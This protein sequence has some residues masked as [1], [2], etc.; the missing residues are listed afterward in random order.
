MS[1][2]GISGRKPYG[3]RTR[4]IETRGW[5]RLEANRMFEFQQVSPKDFNAILRRSFVWRAAARFEDPRAVAGGYDDMWR[6]GVFPKDPD[7]K[8]FLVSGPA[9]LASLQIQN[10]FEM[11]FNKEECERLIEDYACWGGDRGLTEDT[12]RE[13]CGMPPRDRRHV[14]T[15]AA[16]VI[17]VDNEPSE[18]ED[19][20]AMWSRVTESI[21]KHL[22]TT[23]RLD[24]T[25]PMFMRTK[26]KDV[27]NMNKEQLV[28][29]MLANKRLIQSQSRG[30]TEDVFIVGLVSKVKLDTLIAH[31]DRSSCPT[32]TERLA[33]SALE[34]Y[35]NSIA[36]S[37]N[38]EA[39][40]N[41]FTSL[42]TKN[43]RGRPTANAK[44]R[45]EIFGSKA[46]KAVSHEKNCR[47]LVQKLKEPVESSQLSPQRK[48]Q[49]VKGREEPAV[50]EEKD[51]TDGNQLV[52]FSTSYQYP[53][54]TVLRTRKIAESLGAQKFT[55]RAQQHLLAHTHDLDIHNSVFTVLSQLLDK[56]Q[57]FPAMP[58]DLRSAFDRC[59]FDRDKVCREVLNVGREEGKCI[60][61]ATL[62][63]GS[64][65][66]HLAGNEF[67]TRLSKVSI[68]MRWL[69]ISL[70]EDEFHRFRSTDVNKKN[71][72]M[73]IVSHLYLA[74][75]D[76]ILTAWSTFL[77][78][79]KPTHLSL[80][81][82]GVRVSLPEGGPIPDLCKKC[83]SY[84]QDKT[85]FRVSIRE[86]QHRTVFQSIEQKSTKEPQV[87]AS[88]CQL[89][90]HGNCIL[91][92]IAAVTG[93]ET[94]VRQALAAEPH[95]DVSCR[96]YRECEE[97]C[98][99]KLV[100]KLTFRELKEGNFLL[101]SEAGGV[102]HCVGFT[103]TSGSDS[104]VVHDSGCVYRLSKL[105]LAE[106]VET[107]IDSSTCVYFQ[108]LE[109]DVDVKL[110][111]SDELGDDDASALLALEAAGRK[112]PARFCNGHAEDGARARS[113]EVTPP[114]RRP[115]ANCQSEAA[116]RALRPV[117]S[118]Q[119]ETAAAILIQGSESEQEDA[120]ASIPP[121]ALGCQTESLAGSNSE[122][123]GPTSNAFLDDD[124]VVIVDKTLLQSLADEVACVAAA[125]KYRKKSNSFACPCCP[126]RCFQSPGRV[127]DHLLK[128]HVERNQFC[129]SGKKQIKCVLSLHD[130]DMIR[131]HQKGKYLQRSARL[132]NAQ[133]QPPLPQSINA[134]DKRIRL[135]L[136]P[137]GL[138]GKN[139]K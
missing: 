1:A 98:Q 42:S 53:N 81:F 64:I 52:L 73:S 23:K 65:P 19:P 85:G 48:R 49:R 94:L 54:T 20:E 2:E 45:K 109:R 15:Q 113:S 79:L 27:P 134:V 112:R 116:S 35:V 76:Y 12:M 30:K 50:K 63:G 130:S 57:V 122:M 4:M 84:I 124:G 80:H 68:Y 62:Y 13:A 118:R 33:V 74:A 59:V 3:L 136:D 5:K 101:H 126:W 11:K 111:A 8:Q 71:P 102:P 43:P 77:E 22:L 34:G 38:A 125:A 67:L 110:F 39:L 16:S 40:A 14:C 66:E 26:F 58:Q 99:V 137:Q 9:I 56:L 6:D 10:A 96:S 117:A 92:A 127:T 132:L 119:S 61:T 128:Y 115:I 55:R 131:G 133:V 89:E 75:E 60:L 123:E 135:L 17:V 72:D 7:L 28:A 93:K 31:M 95:E 18:A 107:G 46:S 139:I 120:D 114:I 82:D 103:L 78:T 129:C 108:V 32:L 86:K 70:L 83:E 88:Q 138:L 37:D 121:H 105:A 25:K 51:G 44:N 21:M 41:V 91:A 90:K 24:I 36:R 47:S 87:L 106:A 29:S 100:A 69:A 104:C 97:L